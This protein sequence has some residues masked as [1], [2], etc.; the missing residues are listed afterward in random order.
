MDTYGIRTRCGSCGI[1]VARSLKWFHLCGMTCDC[2]G[3]FDTASHIE[4]MRWTQTRTSAD[5]PL[6]ACAFLIDQDTDHDN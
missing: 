3:T 4:F 1:E 2:G 6:P 5:A